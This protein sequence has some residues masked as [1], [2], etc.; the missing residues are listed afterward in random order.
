M[1]NHQEILLQNLLAA[2]HREPG[3]R[4]NEKKSLRYAARELQISQDGMNECYTQAKE[5]GWKFQAH[6]TPG[7]NIAMFSRLCAALVEDENPSG[8]VAAF[9]KAIASKLAI[10]PG[11]IDSLFA[12]KENFVRESALEERSG[13]LLSFLTKNGKMSNE[14]TVP[15]SMISGEKGKT[16]RLY[17]ANQ[18]TYEGLDE[19]QRLILAHDLGIHAAIDGPPGVGKTQSVIEAARILGLKLYTKTC[20]SRTTESHIISFPVLALRD[21]VSVTAHVNGPLC[22]AMEEPGIFY[23]DEFNLLKEDVQKRLNSAFDERSSIDRSDGESVTAKEGFWSVISYNPTQN[24]VS[25]DLEDSVADR[26]I[27]LHYERWAA[28]FKAYV[29]AM[30]ARKSSIENLAAQEDYGIQLGWRGISAGGKFFL[31]QSP[32]DGKK[33]PSD[34]STVKW[35]D[36][37]QGNV[38]SEKPDYVYRVFDRTSILQQSDAQTRKSLEDLAEQSFSEIELARMLSRFTEMLQSLARTGE[39]PLLKKIGLSDLRE[40]EDLELLSLHESSTRIEAAALKHFR[41]LV[42]SG[43]NRYLAQSYAVRLVIDQACFGQYRTKKLRDQTVY[44]LVNL[45]A[46]SMRLFADS[47]KYNTRLITESILKN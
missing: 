37:F 47:T 27:H 14:K 12:S 9:L 21:G 41:R 4:V 2:L 11:K 20:S 34:A 43:W 23:G 19:L 1:A 3:V 38:T 46:R 8:E 15:G 18:V 40:K 16:K 13:L 17:I 10:D 6:T 44:S 35:L 7:E 36:F 31:G 39:S 29:S 26:F 28:D 45:I 32:Q 33:I 42:E 30:N 25:R 22:R 5:S 24:L